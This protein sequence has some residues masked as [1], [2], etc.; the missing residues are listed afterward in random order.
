MMIISAEVVILGL[1]EFSYNHRM[2][3]VDKDDDYDYYRG[4]GR[5]PLRWLRCSD[6]NPANT[7]CFD[8]VVG[9]M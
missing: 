3:K 2:S 9:S 5:R 4:G 7:C 8:R 6:K 1:T